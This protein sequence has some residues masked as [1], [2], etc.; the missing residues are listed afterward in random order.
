M[1]RRRLCR[2]ARMN[3]THAAITWLLGT[4][5]LGVFARVTHTQA[6]LL[7]HLAHSHRPNADDG[8]LSSTTFATLAHKHSH[9]SVH[10]RRVRLLFVFSNE[11]AAVT[12][13]KG[14]ST[15]AADCT[16]FFARHIL[17]NPPPRRLT[18]RPPLHTP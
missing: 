17:S 16:N 12:E 9:A 1:R 3:I 4:P 15:A 2:F 6:S 7:L 13:A 5:T 14:T 11:A 8:S 10:H 18:Q